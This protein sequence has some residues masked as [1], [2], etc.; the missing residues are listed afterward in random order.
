M[1][2]VC[3]GVFPVDS[4]R[5]IMA[6]CATFSNLIIKPTVQL[7]LSLSL[8]LFSRVGFYVST[9]QSLSGFE[10]KFHKEISRVRM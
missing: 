3:V 7:L 9:F 6:Y 10:E 5:L 2:Q 4:S 1:E 8:P